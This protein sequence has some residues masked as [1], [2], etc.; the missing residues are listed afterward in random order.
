MKCSYF[1]LPHYIV[2][3]TE[4]PSLLT[5]M[6]LP[7]WKLWVQWSCSLQP[8]D[9]RQDLSHLQTN[10]LFTGV[11]RELTKNC[12][13]EPVWGPIFWHLSISQARDTLSSCCFPILKVKG[14]RYWGWFFED[15]RVFFAT[16]VLLDSQRHSSVSKHE[17]LPQVNQCGIGHSMSVQNSPE[18]WCKMGTME[19]LSAAAFRVPHA[20]RNNETW[21]VEPALFHG[22]FPKVVLCWMFDE[23]GKGTPFCVQIEFAALGNPSSTGSQWRSHRSWHW[24]NIM[25]QLV[26]HWWSCMILPLAFDMRHIQPIPPTHQPHSCNWTHP[27]FA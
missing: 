26:N 27:C 24:A 23:R 12:S 14:T 16:S 8:N 1:H 13:L 17:G 22:V 19:Y 20:P 3:S 6:V 21:H 5:S 7:I 25:Q 10:C 15:S 4:T 11:P 2:S 18:I 9:W